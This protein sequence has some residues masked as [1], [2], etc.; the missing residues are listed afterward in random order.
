MN[1][2]SRGIELSSPEAGLWCAVIETA[3]RDAV[4]GVRLP[5]KEWAGCWDR[6]HDR[7]RSRFEARQFFDGGCCGVILE[8]LGVDLDWFFGKLRDRYPEIFEG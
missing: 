5:V 2:L 8:A 4:R 3:L 6:Y 7:L 1:K